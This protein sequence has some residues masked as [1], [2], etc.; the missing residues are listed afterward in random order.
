MRSVEW[1]ARAFVRHLERVRA[2][3][4]ITCNG[5]VEGSQIFTIWHEAIYPALLAARGIPG[6]A[7][8][9]LDD[10]RGAFTA[11][12]A[13]LEGLHLIQAGPA[14]LYGARAVR[15]W[16]RRPNHRL[17]MAVDGP[18]GPARRAKPGAFHFARMTGVPLRPAS[19]SMARGYR[20]PTWD[21][22]YMPDLDNRI[23]VLFGEPVA[24]TNGDACARIESA[25]CDR[26]PR[27]GWS[28]ALSRLPSRTWARFMAG[29]LHSGR[30]A[31]G[32]GE[33]PN[34]PH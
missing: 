34:E 22:R 10:P 12:I 5:G 2:S 11:R 7:I 16:L 23:D 26:L 20:L 19:V 21:R 25:L 3:S 13:A 4:T 1:R 17:I 28:A 33:Q 30:L 27:S 29:P 6:L 14:N 9:V 15:D 32:T 18:F 31:V 8:Y 24:A